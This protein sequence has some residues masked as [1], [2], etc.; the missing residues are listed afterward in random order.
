MG[1]DESA[2]W[3]GSC[4]G[5]LASAGIPRGLAPLA[6]DRFRGNDEASAGGTPL[7]SPSERGRD[8]LGNDW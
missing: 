4:L 1:W 8:G 6:R 5:F 2:S 7:Y 3:V